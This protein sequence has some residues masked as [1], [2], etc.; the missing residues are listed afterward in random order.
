MPTLYRRAGSR[1]W[2]AK[3]RRVDGSAWF[4][5]TKQADKR[6]AAKV[7]RS[8]E[9]ANALPADPATAPLALGDALV[10]LK[11]H[12]LRMERSAATL[13]KLSTK[14]GHLVR[15]LGGD[16]DV[17]TLSLADTEAYLDQRRREG[18]GTHTIAMELA[19]LQQALNVARRHGRYLREPRALM[20][21]ALEGAYVPR[22]RWLPL[23]EYRQIWVALTPHRRD[24]FTTYV[25]LGIR[26]SELY[27]IEAHDLDHAAQ[28]VHVRGTKTQ[29][30]DRWIPCTPDV[31]EIL[32]RRAAEYPKGPLFPRRWQ[33]GRLNSDLKRICARLELEPVSTNDL[34]RTFASWLCSRGAPELTV[35]KLLGQRS[36][37]MLRQ[38]YAQLA[39]EALRA[40]VDLLP[41]T[42]SGPVT[43]AVTRP[44]QTGTDS[45]DKADKRGES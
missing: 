26:F 27:K 4:A 24:Y 28:Q 1:Y 5:S 37:K 38:V 43:D 14:G 32:T 6:A 2:W 40:T 12:K 29:W 11:E 44:Q 22:A 19:A 7:A 42:R 45:P 21:D 25:M 23:V 10:A 36:S 20:P 16:R 34:R 8:L 41:S 15:V 18:V 33:K 3:G 39:P 13:E 35:A 9:L 30:A 31:W 17:Q